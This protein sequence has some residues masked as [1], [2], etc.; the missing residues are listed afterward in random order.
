MNKL[1]S[2]KKVNQTQSTK[3]SNAWARRASASV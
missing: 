2:Q 3:V 1:T